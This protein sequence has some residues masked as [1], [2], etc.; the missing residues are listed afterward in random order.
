[1]SGSMSG[2]RENTRW[3]TAALEAIEEAW[4][5][6]QVRVAGDA[7]SPTEGT[8]ER[9]ASPASLD[10]TCCDSAIATGG[11]YHAPDCAGD[12]E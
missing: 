8:R 2:N 6:R 12:K 11:A 1:M 9:D 10:I 5:A 3:L 7:G 4:E